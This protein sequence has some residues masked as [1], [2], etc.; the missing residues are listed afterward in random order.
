MDVYPHDGGG[1][2]EPLDLKQTINLPKTSFSMK[3]NLPQNE[4]KWLAHWAKENL[5]GQIRESR[6]DA[7]VFTL[8][9]GPPYANGAI[10]L[11]TALNKI[12]K[13]F[14][15]KMKTLE[16]FN[17]P[18]LPGWDCHG[19]PIEINVDKELGP[20]KAQMSTVEVRCACRK[21]AEK[22]VD[23][24]RQGF[25]RLGVFG[26]WE[27]PYLTMGFEYEARIAEAFLIFLRGG[28]V[29]RGRKAVFWFIH[30]KTALGAA[31]G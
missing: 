10:H 25:M 28:Y 18:Y 13:D 31:Y 27:T 9:D 6:K 21:Y 3:A 20:R 7:P 24:Q 12:V 30:C 14:I 19:L 16:G 29:Y 4:P 26:E 17:T 23:L 5:Y 1:M 8:H 22:F 15:V 11:G 2:Q